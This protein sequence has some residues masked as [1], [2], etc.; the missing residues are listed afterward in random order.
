MDRVRRNVSDDK[1]ASETTNL[2]NII[3]PCQNVRK[4][5]YLHNMGMVLII[6]R[7]PSAC[8]MDALSPSLQP[9]VG[10][11]LLP[12][13]YSANFLPLEVLKSLN[14]EWQSTSYLVRGHPRDTSSTN[15]TRCTV[16]GTVCSAAVNYTPLN[17]A[18]LYGWCLE[19][20]IML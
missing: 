3:R 4:L 9:T 20:E 18:T 11:L 19:A 5:C 15:P 10:A 13:F 12:P 14:L 16:T 6:P 8:I 2:F 7:Q 1:S 17:R